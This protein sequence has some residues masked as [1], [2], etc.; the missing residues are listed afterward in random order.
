[1]NC[2]LIVLFCLCSHNFPDRRLRVLVQK[3]KPSKGGN[4]PMTSLV[5]WELLVRQGKTRVAVQMAWRVAVPSGPYKSRPGGFHAPNNVIWL[6]GIHQHV[7]V[8]V[9]DVDDVE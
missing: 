4:H 6:A 3:E 1:M 5:V 7:G 8:S 9:V 2:Y